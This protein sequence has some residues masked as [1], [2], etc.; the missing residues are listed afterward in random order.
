MKRLLISVL[1]LPL[2]SFAQ[3]SG[4]LSQY[5]DEKSLS[6]GDGQTEKTAH[7]DVNSP[8]YKEYETNI[9]LLA[10]DLPRFSGGD[11]GIELVHAPKAKKEA[12]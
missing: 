8:Y 1:I 12:P 7:C 2:M 6:I 9:A 11:S 3:T 4:N 5:F 10:L